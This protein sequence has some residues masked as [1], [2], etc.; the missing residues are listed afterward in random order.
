MEYKSLFKVHFS[1]KCDFVAFHGAN[2]ITRPLDPVVLKDLW[3]SEGLHLRQLKPVRLNTFTTSNPSSE[4]WKKDGGSPE[5]VGFGGR[6]FLGNLHLHHRL[7]ATTTLPVRT[8]AVPLFRSV[9]VSQ[10]PFPALQ[11]MSKLISDID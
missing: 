1:G 8:L 9:S 3:P 11:R 6:A 7:C 10:L 5:N 2:L 4:A